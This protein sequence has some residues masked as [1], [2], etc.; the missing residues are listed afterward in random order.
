[1]RAQR[2][3]SEQTNW[4]R[5]LFTVSNRSAG[6]DLAFPEYRLREFPR[7]IFYRYE[8]LGP[9]DESRLRKDVGKPPPRDTN[10]ELEADAV[11]ELGQEA[12]LYS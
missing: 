7:S 11:A 2:K 4:T 1:M 5:G 12:V 6:T 3:A 10:A 9:I 8:L